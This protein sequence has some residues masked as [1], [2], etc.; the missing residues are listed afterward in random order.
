MSSV[1]VVNNKS[2]QML[3]LKKKKSANPIE[4]RPS[5]QTQDENKGLN[6]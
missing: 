1:P 5:T 2:K 4:D 3:E 6:D